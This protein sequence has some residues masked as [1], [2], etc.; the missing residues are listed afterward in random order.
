M[1]QINNMWETDFLRM[2]DLPQIKILKL[3]LE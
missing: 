3:P 1:V 2:L